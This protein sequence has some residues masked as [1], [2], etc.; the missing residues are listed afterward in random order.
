MQSVRLAYKQRLFDV[1]DLRGEVAELFRLRTTWHTKLEFYD[2]KLK[3][4]LPFPY[5]AFL[6]GLTLDESNLDGR[7]SPMK[8]N[9]KQF[10]QQ[11]DPRLVD[12]LW[13]VPLPPLWELAM[14]A[15]VSAVGQH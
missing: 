5:D 11:I 4:H 8:A 12:L 3:H 10:Y 14:A 13:D 7:L 9:F 6:E 1:P 15:P 2:N